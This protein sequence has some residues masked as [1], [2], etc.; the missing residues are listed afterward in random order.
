[1][2]SGEYVDGGAFCFVKMEAT[3]IHGKAQKAINLN[4]LW[5]EPIVVKWN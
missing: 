2:V 1:V 5:M 4:A 3:T